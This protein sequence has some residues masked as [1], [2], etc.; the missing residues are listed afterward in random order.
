MEVRIPEVAPSGNYLL[1]YENPSGRRI[2]VGAM[3]ELFSGA[4]FMFMLEA[5]GGTCSRVS[6]TMRGRLRNRTGTWII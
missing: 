1:V 5:E 3:G 6:H 4:V 2:K